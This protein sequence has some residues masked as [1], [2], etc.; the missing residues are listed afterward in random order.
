MAYGFEILNASGGVVLGVSD[1]LARVVNVQTVTIPNI[2][3]TNVYSIPA[4]C[5]SSNSTPVLDN[6]SYAVV[7]AAGQ[8][9]VYGSQSAG[10]STTMRI[11]RY[12]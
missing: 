2:G 6:L 5:T 3:S 4:S 10:T 11:Y 8:A 12:A 9:T 1:R 7:T